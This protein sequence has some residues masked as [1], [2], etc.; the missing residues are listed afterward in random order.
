MSGYECEKSGRTKT[1]PSLGIAGT[2]EALGCDDL[3]V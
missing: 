2:G 1:T 3:V